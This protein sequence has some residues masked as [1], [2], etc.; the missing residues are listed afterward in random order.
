MDQEEQ[1]LLLTAIP[2]PPVI[3]NENIVLSEML[4]FIIFFSRKKIPTIL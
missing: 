3:L 2:F 1:Y 4:I